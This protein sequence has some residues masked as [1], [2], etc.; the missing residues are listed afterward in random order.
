MLSS[1][2]AYTEGTSRIHFLKL[3]SVPSSSPPISVLQV[4]YTLRKFKGWTEAALSGSSRWQKMSLC[5]QSD[6]PHSHL[7]NLKLLCG[8]F[9]YGV[10]HRCTR[11]AGWAVLQANCGSSGIEAGGVEDGKPGLTVAEL[12]N[13]SCPPTLP[14]STALCSASTETSITVWMK[15]LWL[16]PSLNLKWGAFG[17][18]LQQFIW[19]QLHDTAIMI[20]QGITGA[21]ITPKL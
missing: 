12:L 14:A 19:K 2:A 8:L 6:S 1:Q 7:R 16:A 20:P 18:F 11:S 13:Y 10:L 17:W 3:P 21:E 9:R 5:I 15:E 4:N